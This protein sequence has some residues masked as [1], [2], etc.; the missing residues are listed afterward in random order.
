MKTSGL[1]VFLIAMVVLLYGCATDSGFVSEPEIEREYLPPRNTAAPDNYF[2]IIRVAPQYP[3]KELVRRNCGTVKVISD[4]NENGETLNIRA[5]ESPSIE[6]ANAAKDAVKR[7]RY[8][9]LV[10]D[11]EVYFVTDVEHRIT[12]SIEGRC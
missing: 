9:P 1:R 10:I 7:F 2:P 5:L 12:F 8:K 11:G 3:Q 6:F 4:V